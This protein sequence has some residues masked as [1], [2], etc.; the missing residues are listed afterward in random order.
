MPTFPALTK[1]GKTNR[2]QMRSTK[3][4][5]RVLNTSAELKA[6]QQECFGMSS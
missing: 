3:N 5:T 6:V 1:K 4:E 2:Q